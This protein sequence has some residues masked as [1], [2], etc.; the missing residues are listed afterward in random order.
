ML[1]RFNYNIQQ[2]ITSLVNL[3]DLFIILF[4]NTYN[5][6]RHFQLILT[7]K[8]KL[9]LNKSMSDSLFWSYAKPFLVGS[10][11]GGIASAVIQPID[12]IKVIIQS[13]K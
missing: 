2:Q 8:I 12:T 6:F 13:K 11:S 3:A 7:I 9:K 1:N 10:L 5:H 4:S